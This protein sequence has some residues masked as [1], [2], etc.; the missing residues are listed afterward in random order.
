MGMLKAEQTALVQLQ[1][2]YQE[3]TTQELA[4]HMKLL[5]RTIFTI[6]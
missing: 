3:T 1:T 4:T 6:E 2:K 5:L